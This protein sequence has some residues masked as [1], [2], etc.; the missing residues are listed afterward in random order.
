VPLPLFLF[1]NGGGMN[2]LAR[3][4]GSRG[5]PVRTLRKFLERA[6]GSRFGSLPKRGVPLLAVRERPDAPLRYGYIFGSELVFNAL[7]MYE[8][9]GQG[10]PGLM[11]FP[12]EVAAGYP[13]R[14]ESWNRY[15]PLLDA[16]TPRLPSHDPPNK[17]QHQAVAGPPERSGGAIPGARGRAGL[18]VLCRAAFSPVRSSSS[19]STGFTRW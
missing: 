13:P 1:V 11:P 9:F 15:G 12:H 2:M 14:T 8:R 5:H 16:P 18:Y 4:F 19:Q 3:V 17:R 6:R 10:Y 7:T